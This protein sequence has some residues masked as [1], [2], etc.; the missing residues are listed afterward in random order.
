LLIIYFYKIMIVFV[1]CNY[2]RASWLL[3]Y[4]HQSLSDPDWILSCNLYIVSCPVH[5][6]SVREDTLEVLVVET[7]ATDR[8]FKNVSPSFEPLLH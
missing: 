1:D 7:V 6:R 3:V 5:F 8:N 4:K 2:F